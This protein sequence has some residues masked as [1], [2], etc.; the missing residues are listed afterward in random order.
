MATGQNLAMF[1]CAHRK[2]LECKRLSEST[3]NVLRMYLEEYIPSTLRC[4]IFWFFTRDV[5]TQPIIDLKVYTARTRNHRDSNFLL[6]ISNSKW[7]NA[8]GG[9]GVNKEVNEHQT[10]SILPFG[11]ICHLLLLLKV[12]CFAICLRHDSI[13]KPS[14][15]L[16]IVL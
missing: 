5:I 14:T 16:N 4:F 11:N 10:H 8:D 13:D 2:Y 9:G 3:R 7:A 12:L 1:F 15:C 6:C